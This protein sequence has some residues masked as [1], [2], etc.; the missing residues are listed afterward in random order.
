MNTPQ[1]RKSPRFNPT[2]T[3]C[4]SVAKHGLNVHMT[5][6]PDGTTEFDISKKG[7]AK[8]GAAEETDIE[9]DARIGTDV[10]DAIAAI[11]GGE[12]RGDDQR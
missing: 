11:N 12:T 8:A 5:I 7:P 3:I 4:K 2:D 9:L 1:K 6:H 10:M